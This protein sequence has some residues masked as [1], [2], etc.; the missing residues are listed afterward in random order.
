MYITIDYDAYIYKYKPYIHVYNFVYTNVHL[1][2]TRNG[3]QTIKIIKPSLAALP[4]APILLRKC[5]PASLPGLQ[6][7]PDEKKEIANLWSVEREASASSGW[8]C[9]M[10]RKSKRIEVRA[11]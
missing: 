2:L 4:I 5:E 8:Q 11:K 9:T 6:T 7:M 10:S 3:V 1:R